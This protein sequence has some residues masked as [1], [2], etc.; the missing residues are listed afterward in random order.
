VHGHLVFACRKNLAGAASGLEEM[1]SAPTLEIGRVIELVAHT[2]SG[3]DR[4]RRGG[5]TGAGRTTVYCT[6]QYFS[7][8]SSLSIQYP[9]LRWIHPRGKE[10][11]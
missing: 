1:K 8:L 2:V 7:S 4:P 11:P 9:R 6:L 3:E 5:W 10:G